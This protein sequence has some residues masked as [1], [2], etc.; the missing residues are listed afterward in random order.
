MATI[1]SC[2]NL[3]GGVGKTAI[4]V[5]FAAFCGLRG[6]RTLLVD[7][8][9]QTNATFSCISIE[10][11]K[12]HAEKHGTIANL[13]E[14]RS[15]TAAEDKAIDVASTVK[16]DVFTNVD[17]IPSHLDLFTIDLDV[18]SATARETKLSR[19][20]KT[21]EKD[22]EFIVCDCPPNLTIPTQNALAMSSHFVVPVSPD[23]LSSIGIALL[24]KRVQ[25]FSD[26]LQHKLEH[27]GII[28]S[29]VGRRSGYRARTVATLRSEFGNSVFT[30]ILNERSAV[31]ES[32]ERNVPI[33]SADDNEAAQEFRE[34]S[35][36]MIKR[37]K[38]KI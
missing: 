26:E 1:I 32:A 29:R 8:D 24:L 30:A 14:L 33:Y 31:S 2:V 18:A 36:E 35:L 17:L 27:V 15:H 3:K 20:I 23:Y 12:E 22:Y 21:I 7:C 25:K 11:W 16:K 37:M 10:Q 13:F 34:V 6:K 19:A 38:L 28:V 5:N 9:P 4:A